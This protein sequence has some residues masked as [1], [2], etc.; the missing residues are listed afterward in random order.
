[1]QFSLTT[2][3][4]VAALLSSASAHLIM[5][6]PPQWTLPDQANAQAPLDA[7][8]S[9][10]PCQNGIPDQD[11]K[12]TYQPGS[13]ALLQIQGSAVHGGGSGQM[14]ITYDFPP[15]KDSDW[16]VMTSFEG[17]HPIKA[18]G[19]L[20][21][22][23]TNMLPP[24]HFTVPK[25]LKSGKAVMA[26]SWFNRI[27]NRE[28]YM[29]CATVEIGGSNSDDSGYTSLPTLMRA[30]DGS[31]CEVPEN[32]DAIA[33]KNPGPQVIKAD[34]YT[35]T[36]ISCDNSKPGSGG[37]DS[38]NSDSSEPGPSPSPTVPTSSSVMPSMVSS[39]PP[40][41]PTD[42]LANPY[43]AKKPDTNTPTTTPASPPAS[44]VPPSTETAAPGG[45][46]PGGGCTD[47][48]ITCPTTD[49][50]AQCASGTVI[51]M[52]PVPAGYQCKDGAL[53]SSYRRRSVRFSSE[54][55]RRRH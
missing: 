8:G 5:A 37:S 44:S 41:G 6:D 13:S 49:T 39:Y 25:T 7:S 12:R 40:S 3:A 52:G 38:G 24:L 54:H 11:A 36:P 50:W 17:D 48:E 45:G 46:A 55:M 35:Q 27:G 23:P 10:F 26:W 30:N 53:S 21:P 19:N 32:V 43:R 2:V 9:D 42:P 28:H 33:F 22:D 20:P 34:G 31:G 16:Y 47:G 29:K 15:T 51:P 14:L 4:A 1:M 18:E